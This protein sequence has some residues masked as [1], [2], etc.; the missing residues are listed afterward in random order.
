[1]TLAEQLASLKGATIENI[2][3]NLKKDDKEFSVLT[4]FLADGREVELYSSSCIYSII[5]G[6]GFEKHEHAWQ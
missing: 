5:W 1:M 6:K 4:L 3:A 2:S